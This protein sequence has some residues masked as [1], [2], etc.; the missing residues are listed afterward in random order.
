VTATADG[1]TRGPG[2]EAPDLDAVQRR[3]LRILVASQVLGGAGL[4]AGLT[5]GA[6]LAEDVLDSTSLS[7][8]PVAL[9]TLGSAGAAMFVGSLS[10][11]RGRRAGLT[12][13]YAAGAVGS[14]GVV[15]AAV[16]ANPILLFA[17][18]L[19]Y[20]SGT[21]TN[22]QARYAGGDLAAEERRGSAVS[23]VLVATTF[24]AVA[25]PNLVAPMGGLATGWGIPALAGP[26][27]LA[28]AAYAAAALF[29]TVF[30][31]P[32]PL[33]T[34]RS[35]AIDRAKQARASGPA[36][37]TDV[38]A[39]RLGALAM[40]VTQLAMVAVMT[41]TPIYMRDHGH[42]LGAT[43]LVIGLHVAAMFLPSPLTGRLVDRCGSRAVIAA[44]GVV[45][46]AA[47]VVGAAAPGHSALALTI[48]LVLLGFGWNLGLLGGT[49]L[50][51]GAVPLQGRARL[52]G[53]VDV[54]VAFA[55]AAGGLSS[56]M[57]VASAD[58]ATLSLGSGLVALITLAAALRR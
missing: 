25:G 42:G 54:A 46:L 2:A 50:L 16:L 56:G 9:F 3:V 24:G 57:V 12:A 20:G 13:G 34:A 48:A 30:L 8:L 53:R 33:L 17:S 37:S 39:V 1:A 49:T 51:T 11:R 15:L 7:G 44:G 14:A 38:A 5:V 10:E 23:R 27:L 40:V 29:L 18:M 35:V 31:H 26:F 4:G 47:G 43:G 19:V 58:Y 28:A 22:L 52:Q 45:L 36:G 6:L 41:G 32:D 21:S 55:G